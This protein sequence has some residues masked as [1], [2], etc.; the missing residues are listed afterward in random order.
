MNESMDSMSFCF[1]TMRHKLTVP[2]S[3]TMMTIEKKKKITFE[4]NKR[5]ENAPLLIEA[6][7]NT[8]RS[9]ELY[10]M[11][12]QKREKITGKTASKTKMKR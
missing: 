1:L 5:K 12:E 3:V 2:T 4:M 7:I 8:N 11:N 9:R 10:S 6:E